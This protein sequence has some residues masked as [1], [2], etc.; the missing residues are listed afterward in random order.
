[1]TIVGITLVFSHIS[2]ISKLD[3]FMRHRATGQYR[4]EF[5]SQITSHVS[6]YCEI[7]LTIMHSSRMHTAHLL[8][9]CLRGGGGGGCIHGVAYFRRVLSSGDAYFQGWHTSVGV[10]ASWHCGKAD[11]CKNITFLQFRLRAIKI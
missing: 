11:V 2:D 5:F 6:I 8:A 7:F 4:R 3:Y 1:M 10:H 9:V